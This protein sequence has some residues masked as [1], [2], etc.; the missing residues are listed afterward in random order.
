MCCVWQMEEHLPWAPASP[1][2]STAPACSIPSSELLSNTHNTN[3]LLRMLLMGPEGR[4]L[5]GS[6]F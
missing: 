6:R 4:L 5:T 2:P 3:W 1:Q